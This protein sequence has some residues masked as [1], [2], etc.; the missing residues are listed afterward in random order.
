M[1]G[2]EAMYWNR[3]AGVVQLSGRC[4]HAL[5]H[6]APQLRSEGHTGRWV[7]GHGAVLKM[8]RHWTTG[9]K[10]RGDTTPNTY[11]EGLVQRH[12][13]GG[14]VDVHRTVGGA[15]GLDLNLSRRGE[16]WERFLHKT[17]SS[18]QRGQ[19]GGGCGHNL[20]GKVSL[21]SCP[22]FPWANRTA[23]SVAPL[24]TILGSGEDREGTE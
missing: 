17:Q 2:H 10:T 22:L 12:H 24:A 23:T 14:E 11:L 8:L 20:C 18:E 7:A 15:Q 13:A 6:L 1:K 21:S 4:Q 19:A 5:G 3:H 16:D 9:Q